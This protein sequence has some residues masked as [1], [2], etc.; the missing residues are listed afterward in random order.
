LDI[1]E[2]ILINN[3]KISKLRFSYYIR[4]LDTKLKALSSRLDLDTP[5]IPGYPGFLSLLAIYIFIS[6][7]IN[8]AILET[9]MGGETDSTKIFSH[10]VVTGITSIGIDHVHVLGDTVEKIAWHKAGI[11][12]SGSPAGTVIQDES[13]LRV[14]RDRA[15]EKN[16]FGEL[17]LITEEKVFE[18]RVKVEPDLP[19][20]RSN[21]ALAI[22]LAET[23]LKSIDPQFSMTSNLACS[24]QD[25]KLPGRSQVVN[26]GSQTWFVSS[27]VNE[28]SLKTAISWFKTSQGIE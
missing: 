12:K 15:K 20:Q 18:H 16:I 26:N 13:I 25:V 22:F 14:L 21:A 23:Y 19:Y 17:Q 11:F 8:V 5:R 24:L 27:G 2:R 10:P 3:E 7:N 1:R 6:N 9:G 4:T 28:I